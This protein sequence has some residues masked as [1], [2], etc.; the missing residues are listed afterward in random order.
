MI[1]EAL[2]VSAILFVIGVVGVLTRRNAI[3]RRLAAV[4]TLG[5]TTVICS[6]KTGTL[7]R[8]EMTAT[9]I[10]LPDGTMISVTG[11]GFEP[12]GNFLIADRVLRPA[13]VSVARADG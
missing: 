7:T 12:V 4:E 2:I 13:M 11:S 5:S 1:S 6:D 10:C 9:A 3:I 8:N